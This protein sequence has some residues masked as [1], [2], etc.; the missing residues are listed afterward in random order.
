MRRGAD[1]AKPVSAPTGAGDAQLRSCGVFAPARTVF[2]GLR[3][4]APGHG[5]SCRAPSGLVKARR[6]SQ[7]LLPKVAL[8]VLT[9]GS[10][11]PALGWQK[12]KTLVFLGSKKLTGQPVASY[13]KSCLGFFPEQ[14]PTWDFAP[15]RVRTCNLASGYK[16]P[17]TAA[18]GP[19]CWLK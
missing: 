19:R 16:L 12:N 15:I 6:V 10:I 2:H 3:P 14:N 7:E 4:C 9:A 11:L 17:N 13:E 8:G 18:T 1:M 5:C